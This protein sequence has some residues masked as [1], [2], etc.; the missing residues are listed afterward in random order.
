MPDERAKRPDKA[1]TYTGDKKAKV[2]GNTNRKWVRLATVLVYVLSVS[3]A[4]I[5][6]AVYYC[7]IW[8]PVHAL[9]APTQPERASLAPASTLMASSSSSSPFSSS[10]SPSPPPSSSL[11][12]KPATSS[13]SGHGEAGAQP[14]LQGP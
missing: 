13:K 9:P 2:A 10:F 8:R 12:D 7:L 6:L 5:I 11:L 3:L 1:P 4:A 14:G